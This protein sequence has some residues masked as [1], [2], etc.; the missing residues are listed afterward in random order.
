MTRQ[1]SRQP[2][3]PELVAVLYT[4]HTVAPRPTLP[5]YQQMPRLEIK[6]LFYRTL[7]MSKQPGGSWTEARK[8]VNSQA[9]W[10]PAIQRCKQQGRMTTLEF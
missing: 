1:D 5:G 8:R 10:N 6:E 7:L 4:P 2:P 3:M 9:G